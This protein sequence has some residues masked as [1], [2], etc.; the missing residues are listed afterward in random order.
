MY[1]VSTL[2]SASCHAYCDRVRLD[3]AVFTVSTSPPSCRECSVVNINYSYIDRNVHIVL[4]CIV[5]I[6]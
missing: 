6:C 2:I 1:L 4:V 3:S 5:L